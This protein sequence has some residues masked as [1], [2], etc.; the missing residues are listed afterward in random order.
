MSDP[1][2][3][4]AIV[5]EAVRVN[6]ERWRDRLIDLSRRNPLLTRSPSAR[7][8]VDLR[9]L[10][11]P[12]LYDRLTAPRKKVTLMPKPGKEESLVA[13]PDGAGEG[14]NA[15]ILPDAPLSLPAGHLALPEQALKTVNALRLRGASAQREQGVNILFVAFGVLEWPDP[16]PN[17]SG[18]LRSPLFLVPVAIERVPG[19]PRYSLKKTEDEIVL[20]PALAYRLAQPD[21]AVTLPLLPDEDDLD[22]LAYL[23]AV[24][25]MGVGRAGWT[26]HRDAYLGAFHFLKF[27]MYRDLEAQLQRACWNPVIAAIA[28]DRSALE[29]LRAVSVPEPDGLDAELSSAGEPLHSVLDADPSQQ[30]AVLAA[31][32][33]QSFVLQGPPG[34]GKTQT[35]ANIIAEMIADG[36]RILFVSQ[37]QSA[38]DQ[39][40]DRLQKRGLGDLCLEAHSHKANKKDVVEQLRAAYN[41]VAAVADAPRASKAA[42]RRAGDGERADV[43]NAEREALN[44]Y[45]H[46]LHQP[47]APLGLSVYDAN[48]VVAA[49]SL[50]SAPDIPFVFLRPQ[51]VSAAEY[52]VA[53]RLADGLA[54]FHDVFREVDTHP[55]RGVRADRFSLDL[56]TTV[57][58]TLNDLLEIT[59]L[60]EQGV[61]AVSRDCGLPATPDRGLA[62]VDWLIPVA[63]A[64]ALTPRPPRAWLTDS[65]L[66]VLRDEAHACQACYRAY[67][68]AREAL[69]AVYDDALLTLA[70]STLAD[71]GERLA[72]RHTPALSRALGT[73]SWH[74]EAARRQGEWDTLLDGAIAGAERL[75]RALAATGRLC[76]LDGP[77]LPDTLASAQFALRVADLSTADP[78]PERGWFSLGALAG[79]AGRAK[80]AGE[81]HEQYRTRRAELLAAYDESILD[82]DLPALIGRFTA[83]Y[84]GVLRLVMPGFYRDRKQVRLCLKAGVPPGGRDP[85]ADLR[86][87]QMVAEGR[88]WIEENRAALAV[89]F[90]SYHYRG[91]DTDWKRLE[92][93]LAQT[94]DVSRVFSGGRAPDMLVERLVASGPAVEVIRDQASVLRSNLDDGRKCLAALEPW[95]VALADLP[96]ADAPLAQAPLAALRDWLGDVRIRLADHQEARGRL[97]TLRRD[98]RSGASATEAGVSSDTLASATTEVRRL[99]EEGAAIAAEEERMRSQYAHFFAGL[100]TDWDV[101]LDALGWAATVRAMFGGQAPP[102]G[103]LRLACA[104]EDAAPAGPLFA[105]ALA[106]VA[107]RCQTLVETRAR[108]TPVLATLGT[109]FIPEV[110]PDGAASFGALGEWLEERVGRIGDLERWINFQDLRRLCEAA[111]LLSF[112]DV[113]THRGLS[114]DQ[115]VPAFRKRFHRLWLDAVSDASPPLRRFRG[116]DHERLIRRFRVLDEDEIADAPGRVLDKVAGRRK[117]PRVNVGETRVLRELLARQRRLPPIRRILAGIPNLLFDYKPCLMMSPLSV[118]LYLDA[119]ALQFDAV[120]FD[121]ASQVFVEDALGAIL[122]AKQVIIAGDTR[123][124][125]PTSFF[126]NLQGDGGDDDDESDFAAQVTGTSGSGY[127][128]ILNAADAIVQPQAPGAAGVSEAQFA[129][130]WLL[131]HYRSRHESLIAFSRRW[132]YDHPPLKTFPAARP[133]TAVSFVHVKEGVYYGGEKQS[134]T[135]PVEASR[136]VDLVTKQR[137]AEPG[138]SVGVITFSEVQ[139]RAVLAEIERRTARDPDLAAL[140][141]ADEETE[142]LFVKNI[143]TVQGDERD[144]IFLSVGYARDASGG[145]RMNFGPLNRDGGER[146]LNVAVSR[147]REKMVVVSSILPGDIDLT[148]TDKTGPTRLREFLQYA[149]TST[150]DQGG[151]SAA[152][153]PT[154][155]E[156]AVAAALAARGIPVERQVG[157]FDYRVDLAIPDP[158]APDRYLLG[159]QCDSP[160]YASA[161]TARARERLRP[162]VLGGMGW[163]GRLYQIWS[164]DWVR[165]PEREMSRLLAAV[166]RAARGEEEP[167]P[168]VVPGPDEPPPVPTTPNGPVS[169][170]GAGEPRPT[171]TAMTL[172]A[173]L[174]YFE[175]VKAVFPSGQAALYGMSDAEVAEREAALHSIVRHEGPLPLVVAAQ[176]L[177]EAAGLTRTGPRIRGIVERAAFALTQREL[178]E[179]RG[180]FLW[181]AGSRTPAR[182]PRPG[183]EPRPIEQIAVEE[184][185]E[186]MVALLKDAIGVTHEEAV[187]ETARLMGYQQT[188]SQV[189][190]R[191]EE[192]IAVLELDTRAD[193]RLGQVRALEL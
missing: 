103:F 101:I 148:R 84:A 28:G 96:F 161:E 40:K 1:S 126:Q 173:G 36:K 42:R 166:D 186:I 134:R 178:V 139:Q 189:R 183:D 115:V 137:L 67:Q 39:V 107:V 152:L 45:V 150:L 185:V 35:I 80:E 12:D 10:S 177:T 117:N 34:T 157:M 63:E 129:E 20:N 180:E 85:L 23:D 187:E 37:K 51:A 112:Y 118:S 73:V 69:L 6:I 168:P 7:T 154:E 142:T 77:A 128:S 72:E 11:V 24:A 83:D 114:G 50:A 76:G 68:D 141:S 21:V 8:V 171:S 136:V 22:P 27:V 110:L 99:Q 81:R 102:N 94:E 133:G 88:R 5:A 160:M 127:D 182:V 179:T 191:I 54:G 91:V 123:Q 132:F 121:E 176:R 66:D 62:G 48:G 55:W 124:L 156:T 46:E 13:I 135:N 120:I 78:R 4:S 65:S 138:Q 162:Q 43:L 192:A 2:P 131:W 38:L 14:E 71:V 86:L 184:I 155:F 17:R 151:P 181:L 19:T 100:D 41:A 146:R 53:E 16:E 3:H 188:G 193:V 58:S 60:L 105:A 140:L 95:L 153:E 61:V 164:C 172:P 47:R 175:R 82:L 89:E 33:G 26:V 149:L 31:K 97:L 116:E 143:E 87:A 30:R 108:I 18:V 109:L 158:K 74:A 9:G 165:D 169:G 44:G 15:A 106:T 32:R 104:A 144:V 163:R 98:H 130:H 111:G 190:Q 167:E 49:A 70:P 29:R 25:E 119:D 92:T 57:R 122:R 159:I 52:A 147:A 56:Q 113:V 79:L 59:E 75:S 174:R 170:A 145:M 64:L 93:A 90:G 125:P